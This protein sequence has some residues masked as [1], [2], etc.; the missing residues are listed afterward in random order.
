MFEYLIGEYDV[1]SL[2]IKRDIDAVIRVKLTIRADPGIDLGA[3][4]NVETLPC[5]FD[6]AAGEPVYRS[7]IATSE[8]Q[9][10]DSAFTIRGDGA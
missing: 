9:D 5:K 2:C 3:F 10:I 4:L 1:E 6:A 8:I 7:A